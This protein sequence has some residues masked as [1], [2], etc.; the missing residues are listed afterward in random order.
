MHKS[1]SRIRRIKGTNSLASVVA[2][3][4]TAVIAN[5]TDECQCW[6]LLLWWG[7]YRRHPLLSRQALTL[8]IETTE[9]YC[10]TLHK[11]TTSAVCRLL[12]IV[13]DAKCQ[14]LKKQ[15]VIDRKLLLLCC[16]CMKSVK[17]G[18]PPLNVQCMKYLAIYYFLFRSGPCPES[19]VLVSS[20]KCLEWCR[21][22]S[23]LRRF[24][25]QSRR[26][27]NLGML[28]NSSSSCSGYYNYIDSR[29]SE[30][31]RMTLS[32]S[33]LTIRVQWLFGWQVSICQ[34][35]HS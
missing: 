16:R 15:I 23:E 26:M 28:R 2:T 27:I 13:G 5:G 25:W 35:P 17:K 33:S 22:E 9:D 20:G 31:F 3:A 34:P 18:P 4:T 21:D 19:C 24:K 29:M 8:S 32:D 11:Y 12:S 10:S 1:R 7:E 30:P 6:W 14:S